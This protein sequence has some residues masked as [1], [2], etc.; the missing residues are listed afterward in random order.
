ASAKTIDRP[1]L[2][3]VLGYCTEH[4]KYL[5]YFIVYKVDRFAR[6]NIDHH[7]LRKFLSAIGIRLRSATEES[8]NNDD[9]SS[10]LMEGILASVAQY[11]NHQRRDRVREGMIKSFES[12]R[13]VWK[14]PCGYKNIEGPD[15]RTRLIIVE[16]E[17]YFVR[18]AFRLAIE[19]IHNKTTI[20]KKLITLGLK[21]RNGG[22]PS[23]QFLD[24]MLRNSLYIS[25]MH[26]KKFNKTVKAPKEFVPSIIDEQTFYNAQEI[27]NHN[28]GCKPRKRNNPDFPL[29][30]LIHCY[31]CNK[32]LT[33]SWSNKK[34]KH[35]YYHCRDGKC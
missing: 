5:D 14:G 12:G 4:K 21:N 6:A 19:G 10:G 2:K 23:L 32:L 26:S 24:K 20:L 3:E 18:E 30:G 13:F 8:I 11:D 27:L 7:T 33:G 35:A 1:V 16:E 15:G 9:P 29:R 28:K 25:I 34:R 31:A 17:A 22:K